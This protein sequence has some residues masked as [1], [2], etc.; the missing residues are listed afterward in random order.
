MTGGRR[1]LAGGLGLLVVAFL[2]ALPLDPYTGTSLREASGLA[3]SVGPDEKDD[4]GRP[5]KE[6]L[7]ANADGD[8]VARLPRA[9]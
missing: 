1:W 8:I 7:E 5:S 3:W 9:P 4:G 2:D 6:P